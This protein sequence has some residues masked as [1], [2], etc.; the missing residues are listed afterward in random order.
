[1]R[2]PGRPW[3]ARGER[4][5]ERTR[6]DDEEEVA[7]LDEVS[8]L[9]GDAIEMAR[10]AR[11]DLDALHRLGATGV[12]G[13]LA[14]GGH[15]RLSYGDVGT[16]G[17]RAGV[18]VAL[19]VR[20]AGR[21]EGGESNDSD[22]MGSVHE[23]DPFQILVQS[24]NCLSIDAGRLRRVTLGVMAGSR[25]TTE[26]RAK[27]FKAL[28]D[29]HR[30]AI[31]D[32]LAKHGPQCGT[33]LAERLG[34]SI[35]L[36]SHHWEVLVEAGLIV[37]E[38]VGQLRYCSLDLEKLTEATGGWGTEPPATKTTMKTKKKTTKASR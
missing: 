4:S 16:R 38:R 33:E 8:V 17:R 36:L 24:S 13:V 3:R 15:H 9:E 27:V 19:N 14:D 25:L 26:Q 12:L 23:G 6:V 28:A 2:A 37:K 34:I 10:C 35:A 20:I 18:G 22:E 7:L 32:A 5:V 29:G 1:V 30:V 31:V 11:A 21:A